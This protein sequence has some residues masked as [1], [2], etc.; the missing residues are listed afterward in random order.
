M[1]VS[2]TPGPTRNVQAGDTPDLND[3]L[4][5]RIVSAAATASTTRT[6]GVAYLINGNN[7]H[8][9]IASTSNLT[10]GWPP[11]VAVETVTADATNSN[12]KVDEPI[13]GVT[14][15]QRVAL[16]FEGR[17]SQLSLFPGEYVKAGE[18]DGNTIGNL[19]RWAQGD[20]Q[21]KYARF[22]GKEAALLDINTVSPFDEKLT[23]GVVPDQAIVVAAEGDT[24]VGWFQLMEDVLL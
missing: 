9:V 7:S 12:V 8:V 23:P 2:F 5:S 21:Q 17:G 4:L 1:S 15:P 19:T 3:G 13:S 10:N 14:A 6:R 11:F 24:G 20:V 22:L 16:T 18:A